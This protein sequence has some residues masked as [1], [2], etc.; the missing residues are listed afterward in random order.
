MQFNLKA[1]QDE[2]LRREIEEYDRQQQE[3]IDGI[4]ADGKEKRKKQDNIFRDLMLGVIGIGIIACFI[5][6]IL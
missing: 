5:M 1:D 2:E 6:V 4:K 3:Y